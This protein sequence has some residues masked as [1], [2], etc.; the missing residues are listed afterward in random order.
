LRQ[1]QADIRQ[2]KFHVVL[3]ISTID[4]RLQWIAHHCLHLSSPT[5]LLH[6]Y[7]CI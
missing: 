7:Y 6:I 4:P 5:S 1:L 3:A 2:G